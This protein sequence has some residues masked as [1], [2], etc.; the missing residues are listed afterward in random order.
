MNG[1]LTNTSTSLAYTNEATLG[2]NADGSFNI[3]TVLNFNDNGSAAGNF[4]DDVPFPGLDFPPDNWFSTEALLFLD[5]PAGYYRLGVNS[6]DGFEVNSLPPQGVSGSPIVVGLFDNG[7]GAADTL[8]D[9]LVTT[10][11]VYPFQV[12]YFQ[13]AGSASCE[14]FSV[15]N[16]AT[17]DKVLINDPNDA[18]AIKSYRVL[19]PRD[20]A[21]AQSGANA[22]LE[23]AYGTPPF[24]VQFKTSLSN[25][26]WNPSGSPT[27]N[28]T[29][30]VPILPGAGFFRVYGQ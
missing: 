18:N 29:A 3:D 10:S 20:P 21:Y 17:G 2:T 12:I 19:A 9:F 8:F 4:P 23:W 13:A 22:V 28:R 26:L 7:R 1:T 24:Q 30:S 27:T 25:P 16:L 6:D 5:L 14:F 11:G 15:T